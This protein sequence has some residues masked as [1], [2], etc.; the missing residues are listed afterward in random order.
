MNENS[1][2]SVDLEIEIR[3]HD[4]HYVA[5]CDAFPGL[6]GAGN[7][8][9]DAKLALIHSLQQRLTGQSEGEFHAPKSKTRPATRAKYAAVAVVTIFAAVAL[10][11]WQMCRPL[12]T[13]KDGRSLG[14]S[15][16]NEESLK[17]LGKQCEAPTTEIKE[18]PAKTPSHGEVGVTTKTAEPSPTR[19]VPQKRSV[20]VDYEQVFRA[21][22]DFHLPS[23]ALL[24]RHALKGIATAQVCYARLMKS[25]GYD[26]EARAWANKLVPVA[27]QQNVEFLVHF[28]HLCFDL[29]QLSGLPDNEKKWRN[30]DE[31]KSIRLLKLAAQKGSGIAACELGETYRK[32]SGLMRGDV[33]CSAYAAEA[34]QWYEQA[35]T[36]SQQDGK[37]DA[38]RLQNLAAYVNELKKKMAGAKFHSTLNERTLLERAAEIGG[39]SEALASAN[40]LSNGIFGPEDTV[41]ATKWRDVAA[42]R[43]EKILLEGTDA[44]KHGLATSNLSLP[45]LARWNRI[46]QQLLSNPMVLR[47]PS[48][49]WNRASEHWSEKAT[50]HGNPEAEPKNN[51]DNELAAAIQ[52]ASD[53]IARDV[54]GEDNLAGISR[55]LQAGFLYSK[56]H[57]VFGPSDDQKR[58][59]IRNV[60]LETAAKLGHLEATYE[61]GYLPESERQLEET[62]SNNATEQ[63]LVGPYR[64]AAAEYWYRMAANAGHVQA[65]V[66][67]AGL[68]HIKSGFFII[69]EQRMKEMLIRLQRGKEMSSGDMT[70]A[71]RIE[72]GKAI[73]IEDERLHWLLKAAN[74]GSRVAQRALCERPSDDQLLSRQGFESDAY[75]W[76]L[77]AGRRQQQGEY[78]YMFLPEGL[79][80]P[81]RF[82]MTSLIG[83]I[84]MEHLPVDIEGAKEAANKFVAKPEIVIQLPN[85]PLRHAGSGSGFFITPSL[86]VTNAHVVEGWQTAVVEGS[87][88]QHIGAKIECA[89][90]KND[91]AILSI[92]V[93]TSQPFLNLSTSGGELAEDVFTIG[94]PNPEVQG[95][96]A[97][98]TDGKISSVTGINDDLRFYQTT[99]PIQPGN[100]GGPLINSSGQVVGVMTSRLSD[101]GMFRASGSLP[102]NVS[103]AVKADYLVPLLRGLATQS[104]FGKSLV[105]EKQ[106]RS[107]LVK[108]LRPAVVRILVGEE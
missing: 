36:A 63:T 29:E 88:G 25:W 99:V 68:L 104:S 79:S 59:K 27:D 66:E 55:Q 14:K 105:S 5:T 58:R 81:A 45:G 93:N 17:E 85:A 28:N 75:M 67:L 106:D 96:N 102:Q 19:P 49:I 30:P 13:P 31:V 23:I 35:V 53:A 15:R 46:E 62:L 87:L 20:V 41:A 54:G 32:Y 97:K 47:S 9:A 56:A 3:A 57:S 11:S 8:E 72:L 51:L 18:L 108:K 26:Q 78:D 43:A 33:T 40:I 21:A 4:S 52:T 74:Q 6:V 95:T 1:Q 69:N 70:E 7:T 107:A 73:Q 61:R 76:G 71:Q 60:L 50:P 44:E 37:G 98:Y 103:Y 90:V 65:Q 34:L 80:S 89:D 38:E 92:D 12:N 86:I 10:F 82:A 22:S 84:K 101:F 39:W 91:L 94:F 42:D 77:I 16:N 48:Y 24:R 83:L 2:S 100:S 64:S